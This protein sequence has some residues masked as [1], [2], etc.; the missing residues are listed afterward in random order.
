ML[1]GVALVFVC[2]APLSVQ[3]EDLFQAYAQPGDYGKPRILAR[4]VPT[5]Q[6]DASGRIISGAIHAYL[7]YA[8]SGPAT[9]TAIQ[10]FNARANLSDPPD[11][12]GGFTP[13]SPL[14]IS[15]SAGSVHV[16]FQIHS[17]DAAALSALSSFMDPSGEAAFGIVFHSPQFPGGGV[18]IGPILRYAGFFGPAPNQALSFA[19]TDFFWCGL[20]PGSVAA[21]DLDQDGDLDLAVTG[22]DASVRVLWGRGDGRFEPPQPLALAASA[23]AIDIATGDVNGDGKPDL[24][25]ASYTNPAVSILLNKG[26]RVFL[27]PATLPVPAARYLRLADYNR[28]GILD[29]AIAVLG[30][31]VSAVRILLGKGDGTFSQK[32]DLPIPST[33]HSQLLTAD[34]NSDGK[35]DLAVNTDAGTL[36][37]LLGNGDGTFQ[38]ALTAAAGRAGPA[39]DIV[40]GDFNGDRHPDVA[41]AKR[42]TAGLLLGK[43]DGTFQPAADAGLQWVD[44][45]TTRVNRGRTTV[46]CI[47]G[48]DFDGD[49]RLDLAVGVFGNIAILT[50]KGDGTFAPGGVFGMQPGGTRAIA[51]GDFNRDG[52][53]DL[54]VASS[55]GES[56]RGISEEQRGLGVL[57]NAT[58]SVQVGA[59]VNAA[60]FLSGPVAPGEIVTLYGRSLGPAQ[61]AGAEMTP[62]GLVATRLAGTQVLFDGVPAPLLAVTAGQINA[63]APYSLAGRT[64]TDVQVVGT[65]GKSNTVRLPVAA[66][67]PGVFTADS[68]GR[69]QGAIWNE[70]GSRN[71]PANPAAKGSII[72]LFATGE[73]QT[74]PDGVDGKPAGTPLPQPVLP[75]IVGINNEGAE[76]LY[77]GAVPGLSAGIM[78]LNVRVPE[79]TPSGEAIP[80]IVK[81]GE[82]FSQP[83]V[84]AAVR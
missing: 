31:R 47:S 20:W 22:S 15:D 9:I 13:A 66:A 58:P 25:V 46:F 18:L 10:I 80:V 21:D 64:T 70:D 68:S 24:V 6:R 55:A 26:G 40:I 72:I 60:S 12:D 48:G 34:F 52:Q 62:E 78:Q 67:A 57:I 53:M 59:V 61:L 71:S 56:D 35:A 75:V 51:V 76:I 65:S 38:E 37:V 19:E 63:V 43:G 73:G 83:G 7:F 36:C 42:E 4:L 33:P 1:R 41:L 29:L 23:Q 44:T 54:A 79:S 84:T 32:M 49:G 3:A 14:Q 74:T 11:I 39:A 50:G 81:I 16:V 8:F 28:D 82:A 77:A 69:G 27:P 17:T 5:A 45:P 30:T 2:L